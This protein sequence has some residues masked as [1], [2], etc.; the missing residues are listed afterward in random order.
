VIDILYLAK[1]RLE[2]TRE[3]LA[4]LLKNTNWALANP[5]ILYDDGSTD[6]TL[7]FLQQQ[8][9][10]HGLELRQTNLGSAVLAA[11]HFIQRSRAQYLVKIDNDAILPPDWLDVSLSIMRENPEL[12]VLGLEAVLSYRG[13]VSES[14]TYQ[15]AA[16]VGGLWMARSQ[17]FQDRELPTVRDKYWG[18]SSWLIRNQIKVGWIKPP[19]PVFLLDRLPIQPWFS[20]SRSYESRGWQRPWQPYTRKDAALWTW[21]ERLT[22]RVS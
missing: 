4:W 22:E 6:G 20:L 10:E 12:Q 3:T 7:E 9:V 13:E 14:R 17:T 18:W 8:A 21:W 2:F 11:N 1:N 16:Q 15:P 19:V 5:P